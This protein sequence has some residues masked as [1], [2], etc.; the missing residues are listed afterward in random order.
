M[1]TKK[2][3]KAIAEIIKIEYNKDL[4]GNINFDGSW[5][6]ALEQIGQDLTDYF[7]EQNS[8]F[9]RQKFLDACGL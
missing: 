5:N 9:D 2:S 4:C 1:I 6:A 3:I 8:H 7:A